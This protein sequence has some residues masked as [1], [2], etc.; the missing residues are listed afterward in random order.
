MIADH[1]TLGG[2]GYGGVDCGITGTTTFG[3]FTTTDGNLIWNST[4]SEYD[5]RNLDSNKKTE[6]KMNIKETADA[7]EVVILA[8]G[9]DMEDIEIYVRDEEL[10]INF[11]FDEE[12][13]MV[14]TLEENHTVHI[15]YDK[16]NIKNI[17]ASLKQGVLFILVSKKQPD[18]IVKIK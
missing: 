14:D 10:K 1:S 12:L 2:Y 3:G 15:D 11:E 4:Q 8:P 13:P 5:C 9:V 18:V 16:Y 17:E 6:E 7:L